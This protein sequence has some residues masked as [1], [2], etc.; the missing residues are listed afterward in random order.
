MYVI[1]PLVHV[2]THAYTC[3]STGINSKLSNGTSC[4]PLCCTLQMQYLT[5]PLAHPMRC[6]A[7]WPLVSSG[8]HVPCCAL[9]LAPSMRQG[10]SSP[11]VRGMN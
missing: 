7:H 4:V 2:C 5:Q 1:L 9:T 11:T 3:V 8:K 10:L 6:K